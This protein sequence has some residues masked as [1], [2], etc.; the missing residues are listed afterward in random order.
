MS[1]AEVIVSAVA[2]AVNNVATARRIGQAVRLQAFDGGIC[3]S[4]LHN[5]IALAGIG[6][7][8]SGGKANYVNEGLHARIYDGVGHAACRSKIGMQF[9]RCATTYPVIVVD[10][11]DNRGR[12]WIDCRVQCL[13]ANV[14][15]LVVPGT[16]TI[17]G[18]C[19]AL[20]GKKSVQAATNTGSHVLTG[21]GVSLNA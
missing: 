12:I 2:T 14:I 20:K 17:Q 16:G 9:G 4:W 19:G 6:S 3:R 8:R 13:C 10:L 1:I 18:R 7:R 11:R 21:L 5:R 15:D